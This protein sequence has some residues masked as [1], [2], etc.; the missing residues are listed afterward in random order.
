MKSPY[1]NEEFLT[2]NEAA[3]IKKVSRQ[4]VNDAIK[5]GKLPCHYILGRQVIRKADL[6]SWRIVGRRASG[7]LSATHKAKI[8][9]A[10]KRRWANTNSKS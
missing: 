4:A 10:Q 3:Q 2:L 9:Q 7:P 1:L 6:R 8:S 5:A